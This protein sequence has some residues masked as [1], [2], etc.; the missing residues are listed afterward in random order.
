[1]WLR[2]FKLSP[3]PADVIFSIPLVICPGKYS[4]AA[5]LSSFE[6]VPVVKYFSLPYT[7]SA[8]ERLA[9]LSK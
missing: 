3:S 5:V 8:F 4:V 7:G 6:A 9:Q 2:I 1:M